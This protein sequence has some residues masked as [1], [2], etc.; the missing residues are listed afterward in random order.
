M[1]KENKTEGIQTM[2]IN[3]FVDQCAEQFEELNQM[4][5]AETSFRDIPSWGSLTAL[6]I[7]A[8]VDEE[9]GV[10]LTGDD[11]KSSKT[12]QD[13]FDKTAAKK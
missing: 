12:I 4:L 5:T 9:Y 10:T 7:I 8:M 13:L 11:I 3:T 2:D 6:S 1:V